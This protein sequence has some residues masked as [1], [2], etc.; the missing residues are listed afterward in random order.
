MAPQLTNIITGVVAFVAIFGGV[1]VGM[2]AA[3]RLPGQHL[4]SETLSGFI[5]LPADSNA[6]GCRGNLALIC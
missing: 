4:S 5:Q 6:P 2:F 3:R 1:L